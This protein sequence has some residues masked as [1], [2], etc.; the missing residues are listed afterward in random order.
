MRT[1]IYPSYYVAEDDCPVRF[2]VDKKPRMQ[3]AVYY[4]KLF[5]RFFHSELWRSVMVDM[6]Q[7]RKRSAGESSSVS[8]SGRHSADWP[9]PSASPTL[10]GYRWLSLYLSP[11][12][13]ESTTLSLFSRSLSV[14]MVC[15]GRL[16]F[17]KNLPLFHRKYRFRF[18]C[19]TASIH[20]FFSLFDH[21]YPCL[22]I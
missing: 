1:L 7:P 14:L 15:H 3:S 19:S 20:L 10:Y 4:V 21:Y 16:L 9:H 6:L 11:V 18:A 8:A 13:T 17:V 12:S 2:A 5:S 22:F